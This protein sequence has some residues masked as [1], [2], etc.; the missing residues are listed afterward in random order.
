MDHASEPIRIVFSGALGRMGQALVPTLDAA[1]GLTV[2]AQVDAGDD[3]VAAIRDTDAQVV[4]DFTAPAA[5][6]AN[7]RAIMAAGA[8]GVIGTTGYSK[9]DLDLLDAEAREAGRGL[10]IAPNFSLG[11]VLLQRFAESAVAHIPRVEII[12]TH[13]EGKLDAPSGTAVRTAERLAAAGAAAGP[14]SDDA[15]RG[16]DVDGVRVHSMRL[17]GVEARQ[18]VH[19]AAPGEALVL[20]HDAFSRQCY[21]PGIIMAIRAMPGRVGLIRGLDPILFPGDA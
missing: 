8:Q 16:M 1:D 11:M 17:A 15:A 18:E 13:H 10:L 19:F 7:A 5:A 9:S 20:R 21:A 3:L 6:M 2:V 4:V 12:E 14:A